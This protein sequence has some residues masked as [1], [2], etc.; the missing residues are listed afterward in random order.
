M[1]DDISENLK[2][3]S[4]WLRILF[5]IGFMVATYVS[6]VI[7]FVVVVVQALFMLLTGKDNEN[8]RKLGANIA[9]YVNEILLFLTY[10]TDR[11]PFPMAPFPLVDESHR[12]D[13]AASGHADEGVNET[14]APVYP[15]MPSDAAMEP[16]RHAGQAPDGRAVADPV[17]D[18]D[19]APGS[20]E[21]KST[22][23]RS[24]AEQSETH[25]ADKEHRPKNT[26][27]STGV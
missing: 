23:E 16:D 1:S 11:R 21:K 19:E 24:T 8:L 3:Q 15:H 22:A 7:L 2:Q 27:P 10:N 25:E 9:E 18:D 4:H 26:N 5:M 17:G 12:A 6:G 14:V 13:V 20:T